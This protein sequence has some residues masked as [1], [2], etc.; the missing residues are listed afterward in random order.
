[1]KNNKFP[2]LIAFSAILLAGSAAFFS[3][4]GISKLFAGE[5]ISALIMA[6]SLE[7][8][9]LVMASFLYRYWDRIKFAMKTYLSIAL[10]V[11]MGITSAGIYGFL[12]S[13]YSDVS[14][15]VEK[16]DRKIEMIEKK[17]SSLKRK[18]ERVN[19]VINRKENRVEKII[20]LRKQQEIRLDSLYNK[21]WYN[22][23]RRTEKKIEESNERVKK[24]NITIDSLSNV[25]NSTN[26]SLFTLDSKISKTKN[27]EEVSREIGPLKYI[28]DLTGYSMDKVVNFFILLL[29]F[30]FDP[31]A[32]TLVIATNMAVF[33]SKNNE[34][35]NNDTEPIEDL[36]RS[37]KK[38][39][40][41]EG[42]KY[43]SN[44]EGEFEKNDIQEPNEQKQTKEE[45]NNKKKDSGEENN[46]RFL[47]MLEVLYD[48]GEKGKDDRLINYDE[49]KKELNKKGIQYQQKEI[50]DF[51][52]AC[53]IFKITD[54]NN[55]VLTKDYETAKELIKKIGE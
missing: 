9:K 6:G 1:M 31:L 44:S 12:S 50:E 48:E 47:Q 24:L 54:V 15:K 45:V 19:D 34:K 13:A 21:G 16:M 40:R 49:L 10:I 22:S 52:T 23:A 8:S 25:V 29:I 38:E 43:V 14:R 4:T 30:V 7:I 55:G 26:D 37:P 35:N 39:D 17:K 42:K 41:E 18:K 5:Y 53:N 11:L 2:Y 51:I 32:V 33:L 46:K 36:F 28:S 3:V 20:S 27:N